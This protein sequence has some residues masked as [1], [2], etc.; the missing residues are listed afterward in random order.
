MSDKVNCPAC[1]K[2]LKPK[3]LPGHCNRCKKWPEKFDVPPREFNWDAYLKRGPYAEGK[4]EGVDYLVCEIC[5]AVGK[6]IRKRRLMDHIKKVHGLK[7]PEY[8]EQHPDCRVAVPA[9]NRRRKATVQARYGVDNVFQAEEVKETSR[10]TMVDKYGAPNPMQVEEFRKRAAQT[11]LERYGAENPFGSSE[12]QE[13]I[14]ETN[15]ERYGVENP[16]QC[17]EVIERRIQTNLERYGVEH[18]FETEE[19]KEK[20]RE[21]SLARFG[22]EHPMQSEEGREL[23]FSVIREKYGAETP[24]HSPEVQAKAYQSSVENHEGVHHLSHPDIIEKR[25]QTLMKRY[26]VDN[27]SKVPHIKEKIIRILKERFPGSAVPSMTSP[28]RLFDEL[29]EDRVVYS[30]DWAYWVTWKGGRR[31]NPDFV[32]LTPE[33][34]KAHGLGV[35]LQDL[36]T[37]LV[38]E[39]LGDFWHTKWVGKTREEREKEFIEGYASVGVTCVCVWE[40]DLNVD[41]EAIAEK[42]AEVVATR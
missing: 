1:G 20:Y 23:C 34:Y 13:K 11:N 17:E 37:W 31:K 40:S 15:L 3:G 19:F 39:V 2:E 38:C 18:Y 10:Q 8:L 21:A 33:Q 22:T 14:R 24:F 28:E 36:R 9:T 5:R 26:G 35:P 25:K 30:G 32:V 27:I 41:P 29:T 4:V 7:K 42:V 16:N 6:D 12:I